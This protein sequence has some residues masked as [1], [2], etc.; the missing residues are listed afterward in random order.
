MQKTIEQLYRGEIFPCEKMK[1]QV[2][3]YANAL[4]ETRTLENEF[5][6]NLSESM[7]AKF[8]ELKD[9]QLAVNLQECTQTFVDGYKLGA[10]MMIEVLT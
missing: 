2:E 3:G 7:K 9:K 6:E 1:K 4:K 5:R 8:D 10:Q